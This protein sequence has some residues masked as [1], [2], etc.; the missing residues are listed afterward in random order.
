VPHRSGE[1]GGFG[2][3]IDGYG[4]K[5]PTPPTCTPG[6]RICLWQLFYKWPDSWWA[7][8]CLFKLVFTGV[9]GVITTLWFVIG[10]FKDLG[11][12]FKRLKPSRETPKTTAQLKPTNISAAGTEPRTC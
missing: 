12:M 4:R 2:S 8:W 6:F 11:A 7:N 10:G 3:G 9:I 1:R 5:A